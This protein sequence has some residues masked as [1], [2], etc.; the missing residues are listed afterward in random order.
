MEQN[1]LIFVI[2]KRELQSWNKNYYFYINNS[3]SYD[4]YISYCHSNCINEVREN[5]HEMHL[6]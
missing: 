6:M 3:Q 2:E 1:L 4:K 5:C